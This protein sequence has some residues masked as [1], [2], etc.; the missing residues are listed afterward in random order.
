MN[1]KCD[2]C[3]ASPAKSGRP[4]RALRAFGF[5]AAGL[6][7]AACGIS[8]VGT[9]AA[10]ANS[11]TITA[12]GSSVTATI[13][14]PGVAATFTFSGTSGEEITASAYGGTFAS[15]CDV[16]L[17]VLAQS[18]TTVASTAC[19]SPTGFIGETTLP[20]AGTYT[21]EL[22][23]TDSDTGS[24]TLSLTAD[25]ANAPITANGAAVTF[26]ASHT[27][28]GQDYTFVGKAGKVVTVSM[29]SGTFPSG[30]DLGAY[31]LDPA[32]NVLASGG[33][34]SQS[35]FIGETTLDAK[36]TYTIELVPEGYN[37][38]SNT[39]SVGVALT[40][41]SKSGTITANG[42]A[43]TFTA[44][45]T[46][47]G[48]N[49][50]FSGTA[51]EVVTVS[52]Y[53]GTFPSGCDLGLDLVSSS[54]EQLG[55]TGCASQSGFIGETTLPGTGTYTV[56]LVPQGY[57]IGSNT[58]SL[59]LEVT[60]DAAATSITPNGTV[61]TFK[62]THTG[63]GQNYTFTVKSSEVVTIST[64]DGTFPG[65]CDLNLYLVSSA[66][67]QLGSIGCAAQ[68]GF[69]GETTLPGKGTYEVEL[70]AAASNEGS[71]T[72]SLK[73]AV[74]ED[75]APSAITLN[76]P[77]V[78]F[79]AGHTA[80]GQDY[81]FAGTADQTVTV[82]T[83]DSTFPNG[84]DMD[85]YLISP[86]GSTVASVGCAVGSGGASTSGQVL[87][88]TGT[89]TIELVP[90]SANTGSNEGSVEVALT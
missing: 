65:G 20:G 73:V 49:Y 78:T 32:G 27:G 83:S 58:G 35:D 85:L 2:P 1:I 48:Q 54:G 26:T 25:A 64:Y 17:L 82:S 71:S 24:E 57:N 4:R 56:E 31:L 43:V 6:L 51:G 38:G 75:S 90:T 3:S 69:I 21:L 23:P 16:D 41:N 86:S 55:G 53:S 33:C 29:S 60:K 12:N 70:Q 47:Q 10:F 61:A 88:G 45:H 28:Q 89:Y 77:A 30:C 37:I 62:A 67:E 63:Q 87:P 50:T 84:C 80:Q 40:E 42:A 59:S 74:T 11:G 36:G 79:T 9:D 66:G 76:G 72:G 34:A 5:S 13:S 7:F 52:T 14:S 39:G 22:E 19:V 68:S 46:G 81:T 18:G 44:S 8:L 15:G